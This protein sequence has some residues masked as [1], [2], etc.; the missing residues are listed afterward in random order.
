M[1]FKNLH[2]AVLYFKNEDICRDHLFKTRWPDGRI[3]CPKCGQKDAYKYGNCKWYKC[4]SQ[5]CKNRFSITVGT[6]YENSKLPLSKW[7]LAQWLIS[8]HKKGISS[9][10]LARDL[11][12]GQ[13]AAW[14]MLHRIRKMMEEKAPEKLDN[15]VEVDEVWI[16]GNIGKMNRTRREKYKDRGNANKTLVMGLVQRDGSARLTVIGNNNFKDIVRANVKETAFVMT[17]SHSGYVGLDK[18]YTAHESVNHNIME[19]RRGIVYTNTVEGFFSCFQRSIL[20]CYHQ[21]SRK[22]LQ[23]YCAETAYR[24]TTRKVKDKIRF[25]MLMGNIGCRLKYTDLIKEKRR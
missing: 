25:D 6:I 5:T 13:K 22:H 21:V 8:A 20:G 16:G 4:K 9:P 23:M 14:F 17:D 7:Y 1:N 10:Q 15:I 3:V 11:G 18:E 24:F 2:E 12:I 19:F